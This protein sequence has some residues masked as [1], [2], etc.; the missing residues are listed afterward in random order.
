MAKSA[1]FLFL[2]ARCGHKAIINPAGDLVVNP[3]ERGGA[4]SGLCI[5]GNVSVRAWVFRAA[6]HTCHARAS[7][8]TP[9]A[10]G[11]LE[12]NVLRSAYRASV[13]QHLLL[14]Y[15]K[16]FAAILRGQH[17]GKGLRWARAVVQ[18]AGA[19]GAQ[20][21]MRKVREVSRCDPNHARYTP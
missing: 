9:G 21:L 14:G 13:K 4:R 8:H 20:A 7:L 16:S 2:F 6:T 3:S 12:H 19:G 10:A 18:D 15:N 17:E 11:F 5:Q 1:K